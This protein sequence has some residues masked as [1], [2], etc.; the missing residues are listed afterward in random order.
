MTS[1][2][3]DWMEMKERLLQ[4]REEIINLNKENDEAAKPVELDQSGMGR[5]SRM[6]AMQSQAMAKDTQSRRK[7]NL[8]NI[9]TALE[10]IE[11]NTYGLCVRCQREIGDARLDFDPAILTCINC[12]Q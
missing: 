3:R 9:E 5:L 1:Q 2:Q 8:M 10:R 7:V 4:M 6:D 11:K 12:A